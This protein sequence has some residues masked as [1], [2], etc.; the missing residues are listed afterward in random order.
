MLL[1]IGMLSEPLA[2]SYAGWIG[3]TGLM[4]F[5]GFL[6]CYTCVY[7]SVRLNSN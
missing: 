7:T 4:I 5:Y 3:G 1:G 6:T 2:F